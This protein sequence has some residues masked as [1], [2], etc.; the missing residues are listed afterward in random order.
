MTAVRG[1]FISFVDDHALLI[2]PILLVLGALAG[3]FIKDTGT[4]TA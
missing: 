2:M 3:L 4:R 1:P